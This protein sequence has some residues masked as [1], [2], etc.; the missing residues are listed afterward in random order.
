M[1]YAVRLYCTVFLLMAAMLWVVWT[2]IRPQAEE[3]PAPPAVPALVVDPP[4]IDHGDVHAGLATAPVTKQ[5]A[6]NIS[7][8]DPDAALEDGTYDT[9]VRM[10][11]LPGMRF[12]LPRFRVQPGVTVR[13]IFTNDDGMVH[14]FLLVERGRR[15]DIL[16]M[17]LKLTIESKYIPDTP[18]ILAA[19]P[20]IQPHEIRTLD[21]TAPSE[22]GIYPYICTYPGHG[23]I[24]YGAMYVGDMEMPPLEKDRN[25]PPLSR[26][27]GGD[28]VEEIR[29]NTGATGAPII[30]RMFLPDSGPA[31]IAVAVSP[32][33]NAVCVIRESIARASPP[34]PIDSLSS[35]SA[36]SVAS[37][38]PP[39]FPQPLTLSRKA[40]RD[41]G[42]S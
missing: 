4:A 13:L 6:G 3:D 18:W 36:H 28:G 17:S 31:S 33:S 27:K 16:R 20:L 15:L 26:I 8:R 21:F 42:S 39:S 38:A 19:T 32:T 29:L 40:R 9:I 7:P 23:A 10:S 14:N 1:S 35:V 34:C 22:P 12:G 5:D 37:T 30:S 2:V 11:V 25:I 24:M 41:V